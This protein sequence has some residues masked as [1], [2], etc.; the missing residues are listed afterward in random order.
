MVAWASLGVPYLQA[1]G[2][3][4][5]EMAAMVRIHID[6]PLEDKNFKKHA[7]KKRA[8]QA[9]QDAPVQIHVYDISIQMWGFW[10]VARGREDGA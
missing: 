4:K 8:C 1:W 10:G 5:G 3:S 7:Q 9:S 2:A 6:L